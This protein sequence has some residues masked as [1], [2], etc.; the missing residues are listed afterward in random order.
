MDRLL[1]GQCARLLKEQAAQISCTRAGAIDP[2]A[3]SCGGSFRRL[4]RR[5][6]IDHFRRGGHRTHRPPRVPCL[7]LTGRALPSSLPPGLRVNLPAALSPTRPPTRAATPLDQH[8]QLM[9]R[10]SRSSMARR[11]RRSAPVIGGNVP[12]RVT[13]PPITGWDV[14]ET[15]PQ[16]P[17]LTQEPATATSSS[18]ST[19]AVVPGPA[20]PRRATRSDSSMPTHVQPSTITIISYPLRLAQP[21]ARRPHEPHNEVTVGRTL[22]SKIAPAQ[23]APERRRN[24]P[25]TQEKTATVDRRGGEIVDDLLVD[26]LCTHR[27]TAPI[28]AN[29]TPPAQCP[30][31]PHPPCPCP[32]P[33]PSEFPFECPCEPDPEPAPAPAIAGCAA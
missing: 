32:C 5:M 7:P 6:G 17:P 13:F 33:C 23:N 22:G 21:C 19:T 12:S 20:W 11:R 18:A 28:S 3:R 14:P 30:L 15:P 8:M 29:S 25:S 4:P 9:S 2:S 27:H 31:H 10:A 24:R 1:P 26:G 16:Q